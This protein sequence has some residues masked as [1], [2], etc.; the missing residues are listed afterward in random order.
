MESG[1]IRISRPT[2]SQLANLEKKK[3]GWMH[4]PGEKSWGWEVKYDSAWLSDFPAVFFIFHLSWNVHKNTNIESEK[5]WVGQWTRPKKYVFWQFPFL[6]ISTRA[7]KGKSK[8]ER[9]KMTR[10][11]KKAKHFIFILIKK[12]TSSTLCSIK[13]LHCCCCCCCCWTLLWWLRP[14][15]PSAH[16]IHFSQK[17]LNYSRTD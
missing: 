3:L 2:S 5:N 10:K 8:R 9:R 17:L 11:D 12:Q 4:E 7:K 6:A 16:E 13:G 1:W 15:H 14:L